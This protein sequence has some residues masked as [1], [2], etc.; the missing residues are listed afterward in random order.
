MLL[1]TLTAVLAL[2]ASSE[3]RAAMSRN[4]LDVFDVLLLVFFVPLFSWLAFGFVSSTMGFIQLITGAHPGLPRC[5]ALAPLSRRTAVLMP[6][7]NESV[8]GVFGRVRAMTASI[9]AAGAMAASTS[10]S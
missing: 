8:E 4:G 10:S 2:A 3:V 5:P 1:I 9:H 6:V 7:Y